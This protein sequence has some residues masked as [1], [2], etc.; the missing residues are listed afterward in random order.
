MLARTL[1]I[2]PRCIAFRRLNGGNAT[3]VARARWG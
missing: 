3:L 1:D 2:T